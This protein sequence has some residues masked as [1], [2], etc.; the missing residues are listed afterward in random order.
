LFLFYQEKRKSL[1]GGDEPRQDCA[2][3]KIK[4]YLITTNTKEKG[5]EGTELGVLFH[6]PLKS[7]DLST[8]VE[9]TPTVPLIVSDESIL[10]MYVYTP[11][12]LHPAIRHSR[13]SLEK[14]RKSLQIPSLTHSLRQDQS[15]SMGISKGL[16]ASMLPRSRFP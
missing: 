2:K 16:R 13:F 10:R 3:G 11:R 9:M 8:T 15:E 5:A 1:L 12:Y 7:K 6:Q 4:Y 14:A